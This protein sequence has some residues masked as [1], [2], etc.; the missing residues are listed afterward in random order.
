VN[1][2]TRWFR[3]WTTGNIIMEEFFIAFKNDRLAGRVLLPPLQRM[4]SFKRGTN[5]VED[6]RATGVTFNSNC[7]VRLVMLDMA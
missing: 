2:A 7:V 1:K 6:S 3:T 4:D 5:P